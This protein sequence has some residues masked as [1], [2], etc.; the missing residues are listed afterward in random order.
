MVHLQ[1][2]RCIRFVRVALRCFV[3]WS[4]P[5]VGHMEVREREKGEVVRGSTFIAKMSPFAL[6][7]VSRFVRV[8]LRFF[9]VWSRPD[10][11]HMEMR[12]REKGEVM[13]GSTFIAK[14]SSFALNVVSSLSLFF[15]SA[16]LMK[17]ATD[18]EGNDVIACER[19]SP[20]RAGS[21]P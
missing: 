1:N 18:E 8:A 3:V 20:D 15:C 16:H 13:R 4:R 9:F 2:G 14:M 11:G 6:N 7:V 17:A 21:S 10:V 19:H 12:Q 5:D